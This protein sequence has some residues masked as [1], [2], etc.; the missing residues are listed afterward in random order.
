[1][2]QA[3]PGPSHGL[4]GMP[5]L[6]WNGLTQS[7]SPEEFGTTILVEEI[8][9][10]YGI[11]GSQTNKQ[12]KTRIDGVILFFEQEWQTCEPGKT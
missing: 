10:S 7:G 6:F 9:E 3:R 11:I 2:G 4:Q 8:M 5:I 1:M 12:T